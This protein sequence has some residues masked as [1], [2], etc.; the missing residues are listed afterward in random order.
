LHVAGRRELALSGALL[1]AAAGL[2][3]HALP[4]PPDGAALFTLALVGAGVPAVAAGHAA[5]L[6]PGGHP[7]ARLDRA[8]AAA[9][10]AVTL[11]LVGVVSALVFDPQRSGCFDCPHNLLLVHADPGAAGGLARW[12]PRAAAATEVVLA[13]LIVVR[14]LRRAPIART[15]A[16]PVSLAAVLALGLSAA[17]DLRAANGI[18]GTAT[19]R[20]LWL[21]TTIALGLVAVGLAWRPVRAILVRGALGR[22]AVAAP[23]NAHDV[24]DVLARALGDPGVRLLW[25]HPETRQ[26]TGDDGAAAVTAPGRVRTAVELRRDACVPPSNAR[27]ASS[28]G[29]SIEPT[30]APRPNC[31]R[32]RCEPRG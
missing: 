24:R 21:S 18:A 17:E 9:A 1:I 13:V 8:A 19:D 2:G 14:L 12:A 16:V 29:S 25:P 3:L 28:P 31:S 6:H 30:C 26:P 7:S 4:E 10:Y 11:G 20:D 23:A 22:L 5:L 32:Q 27:A 15:I